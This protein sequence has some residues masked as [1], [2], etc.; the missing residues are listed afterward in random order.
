MALRVFAGD[1]DV[2]GDVSLD[3]LKIARRNRV[4]R[5][6]M[7]TRVEKARDGVSVT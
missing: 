7:V 2:G 3:G 4:C 1:V 5:L 6:A